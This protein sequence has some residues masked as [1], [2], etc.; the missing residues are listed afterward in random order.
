MEILNKRELQQIAFNHLSDI[1]YQ[2]FMNLYKSCT[3]KP[4]SFFFFCTT[5]ASDN[6]PRFRKNLFKRIKKL[7]L[8]IDYKIIDKKDNIL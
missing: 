8:T 4:Y 7:I 2:D 1:D 5:L 6:S 3:A